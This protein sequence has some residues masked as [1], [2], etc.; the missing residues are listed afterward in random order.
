[1]MPGA[2]ENAMV[3]LEERVPVINFSWARAIG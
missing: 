1:M 3:A 2:K